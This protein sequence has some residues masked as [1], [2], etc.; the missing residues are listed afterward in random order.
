MRGSSTLAAMIVTETHNFPT[1]H[2]RCEGL[3]RFAGGGASVRRIDEPGE[4]DS[5]SAR[6]VG[7]L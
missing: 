3:A 4:L 5:D 6:D 7:V 1:R 2:V